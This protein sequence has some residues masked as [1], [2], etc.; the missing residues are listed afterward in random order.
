MVSYA[1]RITY[2]D[3]F[4]EIAEETRCGA[5]FVVKEWNW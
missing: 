2:A 3:I 1:K 5:V 4:E